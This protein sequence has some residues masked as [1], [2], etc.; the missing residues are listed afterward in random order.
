MFICRFGEVPSSDASTACM[1]VLGITWSDGSTWSFPTSICT[2]STALIMVGPLFLY[3]CLLMLGLRARVW[4][5]FPRAP[6]HH[7]FSCISTCQSSSST[8]LV[9]RIFRGHD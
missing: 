3:Y 5:Y 8:P 9:N 2:P 6:A 4:S 7:T 1:N